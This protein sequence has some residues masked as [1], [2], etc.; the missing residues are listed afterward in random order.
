MASNIFLTA[1]ILLA[2]SLSSYAAVTP[3]TA[4][5]SEPAYQQLRNLTLDGEAI[6]VNNFVLKRD[7]GQFT[8]RS[9]TVCFVAPVQGKVTGAVFNGDGNF[10]LE[11]AQESER[12]SLKLLT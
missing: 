2:S 5:T 8:L 12:K 7:A 9:E 10:V 4:T 1:T 3:A 6:S 11:P